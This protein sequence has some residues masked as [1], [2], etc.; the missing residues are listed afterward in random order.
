[1][2]LPP[3]IRE[4]IA[5][6][7]AQVSLTLAFQA[8]ALFLAAGT[9][10]WSWAWAY[11]G[12]SLAALVINGAFLF[13]RGPAIIAERGLAKPTLA[14]DK[15]VSAGWSL[16]LFVLVPLTAGF[17]RRFGWTHGLEPVW[18][19]AGALALGSGFG[20]SGW[21]MV[22]NAYFSTA[23]RLQGERGQTVCRE[24]PYRLLRHPGYLGFILQSFGTCLILGSLWSLVPGTV[25][26]AFMIVRTWFEDRF[27]QAGLVGY[28]DYAKDVRYRLIPRLW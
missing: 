2:S 24:G 16:C 22:V 23:V 3:E 20:L 17:D 8:A 9:V 18:N 15:L 4:G 25:A 13:R 28:T 27:L 10:R 1:M 11:L 5:R 26:A 6:R 21:A 19:A 14:W 7:A 12:I